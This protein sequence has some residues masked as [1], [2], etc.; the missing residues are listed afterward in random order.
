M[1]KKILPYV[2]VPLAA[3]AIFVGG[4][5]TGVM[6]FS[7][8]KSTSLL[9]DYMLRSV[10]DTIF[11]NYLDEGKIEQARQMLLLEQDNAIITIHG[12]MGFANKQEYITGC[13]ILKRIARYRKENPS[14]YA[15]YNYNVSGKDMEGIKKDIAKILDKCESVSCN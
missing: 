15:N 7:Q 13:N 5:W 10:D 8:I 11:L 14:L 9:Q 12:L 1:I 4:L 6:F 2:L 3:I